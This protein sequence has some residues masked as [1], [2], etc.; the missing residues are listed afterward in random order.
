MV[1]GSQRFSQYIDNESGVVKK[2]E[3]SGWDDAF[4]D[5]VWRSSWFY[6]SML[7]IKSRDRAAFDKLCNDHEISEQLV[8]RFL[9][10]FRDHN[11]NADGW[12]LPK[13]PTQLFSGDQL[14]P[15]LF[16]ITSVNA[17][18]SSEANAIAIDLLN[19]LVELDRRHGVLSDSHQGQIRDNQR[20]AID[21][22][23][24]MFGIEYLRG[25]RRD[26]A[27]FAFSAALGLNTVIAQT[28]WPQLAT[29]D[30]Y[31]V[32][33]SI[34]LV[35]ASCIKW[36]KDDEDVDSWRK[37]F[38]VHADKGWGPAFRIVAGRS[39]SAD[40][41][42]KYESTYITRD[43]DN[44]IVMAQRPAKYL[45]GEFPPADQESANRWLVIDYMVLKGL[46]LLWS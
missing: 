30:A 23:C 25:A 34:G 27:K 33:N 42:E 6:S 14:A 17:H 21:I 35:S 45:S 19:G 39:I 2:P 16:L 5:G 18:G 15:L 22:A 1:R 44:D 31:A 38:R 11:T 10:Y 24:R 7:I 20:F 26:L 12:S 28:E 29:H 46:Q 4:G 41:V 13:N 43:H 40:E 37:N 32:F 9:R 36:G 3:G 8:E